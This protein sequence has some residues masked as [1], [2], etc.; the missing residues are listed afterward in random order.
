MA[1]LATTAA[2]GVKD[3]SRLFILTRIGSGKPRWKA[4]EFS[5]ESLNDF[6]KDHGPGATQVITEYW[7]AIGDKAANNLNTPRCLTKK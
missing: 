4:G 1:H 7:R 6:L 2:S 3:G 5:V